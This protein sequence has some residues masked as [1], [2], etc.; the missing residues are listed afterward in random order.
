MRSVL[1][2]AAVMGLLFGCAPETTLVLDCEMTEDIFNN[3][4]SPR[5]GDREI[6]RISLEDSDSMD[7]ESPE[8]L[9]MNGVTDEM[10]L[11]HETCGP[12]DGGCEHGA[13]RKRVLNRLTGEFEISVRC[14]FEDG[15]WA[16]PIT[17]KYQCEKADQKF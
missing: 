12:E 15:S 2:I 10:I 5:V 6:F 7:E 16:E 17:Q 8:C 1:A 3:T 11:Y 4:V 14:R 9:Y 13:D